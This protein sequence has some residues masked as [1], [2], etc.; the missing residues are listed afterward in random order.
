LGLGGAL[1]E[2]EVFKY[3]ISAEVSQLKYRDYVG[4]GINLACRLQTLAD[5]NE[6]VLN[7]MLARLGTIPFRVDDSPEII[8]E[9]HTLKG[10][11]NEDR[12]RVLFYER[13]LP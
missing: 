1:V 10:L 2:E 5:V 12:N 8:K 11:K 9:L 7:E 4:Y 6:L 3:E 13:R